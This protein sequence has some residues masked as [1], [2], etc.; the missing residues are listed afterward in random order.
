MVSGTITNIR[1]FGAFVDIGGL[2]GLL[3]IAEI[4]YSRV[5]NI[6]DV[7]QVG[8]QIEVAVKKC[9][10]ENERFSFS[11][12]DTLADPWARAKESYPVGSTHTGKV[13]R[14]SKFGAFITLEGGIDGLVHISKIGGEQ[15]IRHPQ[16]VLKPGQELQVSIEKVDLDEKRIS[17]VPVRDKS[18]ESAET[19]YEEKTDAGMGTFADLFK[20][21]QEK[22]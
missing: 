8:Q 22:R 4:S 17:L 10:W 16:D 12:R 11:L 20:K 6:E 14:L 18:E 21:A 1:D 9:D 19:S 5:E 3:P 15:R 2:E 13:S 7:L